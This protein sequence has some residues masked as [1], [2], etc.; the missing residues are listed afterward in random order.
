MP[1]TR[2]LLVMP[3]HWPRALLRAE[4]I[5]R[6]YDVVGAPDLATALLARPKE[7]GRGP[8]R[9]ILIDQDALVE[10]QSNLLDLLVSRYRNPRLVLL[11]RTQLK[12]PLGAWDKIVPRPA[13][14]GQIANAVAETL[15]GVQEQKDTPRH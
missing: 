4:L 1:P 13:L 8:V 9:A 2:I 6:G 7:K 10:P 11:P 3:E 15:S 12:T 5:E 14:I